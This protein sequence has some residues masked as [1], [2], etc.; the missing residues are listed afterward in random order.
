MELDA[1]DLFALEGDEQ[2]DGLGDLDSAVLGHRVLAGEED[3]R[4]L[5]LGLSLELR[6]HAPEGLAEVLPG[7][8]DSVDSRKRPRWRGGKRRHDALEGGGRVGRDQGGHGLRHLG[9]FAQIGL[10]G[11]EGIEGA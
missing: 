1:R 6:P 9:A 2:G 7:L 3:N 5:A 8:L 4:V 10:A 11:E